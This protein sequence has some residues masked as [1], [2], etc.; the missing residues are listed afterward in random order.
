M[1]TQRT[2]MD[3]ADELER[4]AAHASC[5][6]C[7]L[8]YEETPCDLVDHHEGHAAIMAYRK[9]RKAAGPA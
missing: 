6:V 5:S 9:A 2:L 4:V 3:A 8:L 7:G 1:T